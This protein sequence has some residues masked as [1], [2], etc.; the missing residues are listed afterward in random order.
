MGL[1]VFDFL[2]KLLVVV[3][4]ASTFLFGAFVLGQSLIKNVSGSYFRKWARWSLVTFLGVVAVFGLLLAMVD[5]GL[6]INCFGN[7]AHSQGIMGVTRI[8]ALLWISTASIL[9]ARD[10]FR[11]KR[12]KK[13]ISANIVSQHSDFVVVSDNMEAMTYGV[14]DSQVVIPELVF[15]DATLFQHV[16][17]HEKVHAKNRDGFWSLLEVL[18]L[19]LSWFNPFSVLFHNRF[20][21]VVEM[22]TDEQAVRDYQLEPKAYAKSLISLLEN[23]GGLTKS[24]GMFG[25]SFDFN[26]MQTRMLNLRSHLECANEE[27]SRKMLAALMV[28]MTVAGVGQAWASVQTQKVKSPG[29]MICMQVQHEMVIEKLLLKAPETNK[30]D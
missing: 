13:E 9:F 18:S 17:C 10:M 22:A 1:S 27:R 14:L 26:Q 15:K 2:W 29:E 20:Q 24:Y 3:T 25:A 8:L 5:Q 30:C 11:F 28:L 6:Q 16:L 4:L 7:F 21:L 19:R 12:I 23:Q